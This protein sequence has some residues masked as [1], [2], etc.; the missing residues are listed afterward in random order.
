MQNEFVH[1]IKLLF[2]DKELRLKLSKNARLKAEQFSWKSIEL[3]WRKILQ[4]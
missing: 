1:Q 2:E 4:A 3:Q